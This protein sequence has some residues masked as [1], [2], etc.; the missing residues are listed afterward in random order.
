MD[1]REFLKTLAAACQKTAWQ[2]HA[3]YLRNET[4]LP[5]KCIRLR[6][7]GLA[8]HNKEACRQSWRGFLQGLAY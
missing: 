3:C 5:V 1:R 8:W 2:V 7:Y 4:T 6:K